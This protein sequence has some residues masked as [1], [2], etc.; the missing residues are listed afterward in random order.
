MEESRLTP[1]HL[2]TI[3]IPT[4]RDQHS[5]L[6]AITYQHAREQGIKQVRTT[7][8][9]KLRSYTKFSTSEPRNSVYSV[10]HCS[11]YSSVRW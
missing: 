7:I 4:K 5:L 8:Y 10:L 2:V 3:S 9:V 6:I 11:K 1:L